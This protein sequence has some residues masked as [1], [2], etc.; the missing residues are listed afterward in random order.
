MNPYLTTCSACG[1]TTSRRYAREHGDHC[2]ACAEPEEFDD[3]PTRNARLLEVGYLA[4]AA[5]EGH[6]DQGDF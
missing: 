1:G 3:T 4:Y 5:E 6:F 2:K